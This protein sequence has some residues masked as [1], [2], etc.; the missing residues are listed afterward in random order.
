[1]HSQTQ[2][3][4]EEGSGLCKR[5]SGGSST[6]QTGITAVMIFIQLA[7]ESILMNIYILIMNIISGLFG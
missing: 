6:S 5:P 4:M 7:Y 3:T 2:P 1:M